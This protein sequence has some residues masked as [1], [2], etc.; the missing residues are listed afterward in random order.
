M[1]FRSRTGS[2][3]TVRSARQRGCAIYLHASASLLTRGACKCIASSTMRKKIGQERL[4]S[5]SWLQIAPRAI[6]CVA[7]L[8]VLKSGA[9]WFGFRMKKDEE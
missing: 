8:K 5:A 6:K 1:D 7:P 3:R 9:V 2:S 4:C